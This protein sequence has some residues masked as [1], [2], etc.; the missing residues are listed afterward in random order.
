[1]RQIDPERW[2]E[3]YENAFPDVYRVYRLRVTDPAGTPVDPL[4]SRW[5]G[6]ALD[7]DHARDIV[8]QDADVTAVD[9][10]IPRDN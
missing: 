9:I 8:V 5:W 7:F 1:M 4:P 6:D 10:V 2:G 3:L